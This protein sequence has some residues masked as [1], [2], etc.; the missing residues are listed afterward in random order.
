MPLARGVPLGSGTFY[1][2]ALHDIG[3][4]RLPGQFRHT[5]DASVLENPTRWGFEAHEIREEL[6]LRPEPVTTFPVNI[7]G[8]TMMCQEAVSF[9]LVDQIRLICRWKEKDTGS[10]EKKESA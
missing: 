2:F 10:P 9:K 8:S 4:L 5:W 1:L 3:W 7:D 6:V